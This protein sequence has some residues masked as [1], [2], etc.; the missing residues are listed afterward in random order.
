MVD[1]SRWA[2]LEESDPESEQPAGFAVALDGGDV[3]VKG[4]MLEDLKNG[5]RDVL[6]VC[7]VLDRGGC[8]A[9]ASDGGCKRRWYSE[10]GK[11]EYGRSGCCERCF[12]ELLAPE[13]HADA[14]GGAEL[15][16]F[17]K[18]LVAFWLTVQKTTHECV[19]TRS[20]A[21]SLFPYVDKKKTWPPIRLAM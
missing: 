15:T 18:Q 19:M 21:A 10:G 9:C 20:A 6:G 8:I 3:H 5:L 7:T 1:Y 12:D 4:A 17:G 13:E 11:M 14:G 16:P 2:Q